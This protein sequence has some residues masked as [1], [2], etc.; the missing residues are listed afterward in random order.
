MA[1]Q[2]S[3]QITDA[4]DRQVNWLQSAGFGTFTD[5]VRLAVDRM[6]NQE[7]RDMNYIEIVVSE[8]SLFGGWI[9]MG[10]YDV[11]A[12]LDAY[13]HDLDKKL[14]EE[15]DAHVDVSHGDMDKTTVETDDDADRA[16][17][18]HIQAE[19]YE[20]Y[21]W[22]RYTNEGLPDAVHDGLYFARADGITVVAN[23]LDTDDGSEYSIA[24]HHGELP[25]HQTNTYAAIDELVTAMTGIADAADWRPVTE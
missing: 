14:R 10:H 24:F 25:A 18:D 1:R 20:T 19:I 6:Y 11:E 5:I 3:V 15:F 2:T 21:T 8:D 13:V 17:V 7:V 16:F 12:S 23:E 4:T 22:V 9:D